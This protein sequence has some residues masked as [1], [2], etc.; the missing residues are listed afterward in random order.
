MNG[1]AANVDLAYEKMP[2]QALDEA[3]FDHPSPAHHDASRAYVICTTPRSGS[4]LLCRQLV[5]A[6]LG[7]PSEY[8]NVTHM[9]P[10]CERWRIDPR[11]TRAYLRELRRRR[12][13][14]NGV[15]GTKL[16][17]TQYAERRNALKIL[18][19]RECRPILLYRDDIA[20][21]TVSL[22]LSYLTGIWDFD[23][24]VYTVPRTDLTLG[25]EAHLRE[26]E[27]AILDQNRAWREFFAAQRLAPLVVRYEDVVADQ[28]GAVSRVA[29][30]LGLDPSAYRVPPPEARETSFTPEIEAKRRALV[31]AL[32]QRSAA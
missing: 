27:R 12:T 9:L 30:L 5:N 22:H 3:R 7:V 31:D 21:Q 11:D 4:W 23:G 2:E 20:S 1:V 6:G 29:A 26:C 13:T 28:A 18:L 19:M 16:L 24:T 15:W 8:L 32:R 10:L 14:A 25:D 17:W